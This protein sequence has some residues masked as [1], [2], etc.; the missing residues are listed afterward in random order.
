[1]IRNLILWIAATI[2]DVL[3]I[4]LDWVELWIGPPDEFEWET[5]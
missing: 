4:V 3:A 2:H 5:Q 1:V